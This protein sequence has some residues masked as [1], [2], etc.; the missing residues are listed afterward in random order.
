MVGGGAGAF[1]GDVHRL[2]AR[3][4]GA[5]QLVCG[6]FSR[7]PDNCKKTGASLGLDPSRCYSDY[8]EMMAKEAQLPEN[9]RMEFVSIVTPNHVHFPVAKAALE[10]GFHVLSDKPATLNLDEARALGDIVLKSG[11]AYGLTHTYLGYPLVSAARQ[12]IAEGGIG[13][14]RKIYAEYIQ[15]WL[16]KEV[17]NKQADWR[18][19]P[20]R[21]GISGCMGDIGTHA[22]NLV[23]YV[24]GQ[25]MSHVAADLSIFV[26]G[27]RLDD[28]GSALFRMDGGAKGTLSASQVCVGRENSLSIRVYGETG[29]LEWHQEEP[30]TLLRTYADRPMEVIR[31]AHGYLPESIQAQ[32]RTPPG[33]PEGYLE[34]FANIYLE[35]VEAVR[36]GGGVKAGM[37]PAIR[38][39]AF[40]EALVKSSGNNAAWTE[41][42]A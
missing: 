40:V 26:D 41:I 33:H 5:V 24:T 12:I 28:D 6:A 11:K 7:D 29:G 10:A 22:H 38:G 19:D 17:D 25:R 39:M 1:I 31:S 8:E 3:L 30:N 23:E 27:R 32:Y 16:A 34:A 36:S 35:F 42:E 14:V 9:E 37:E 18:T 2:A 4:D 20:S 13:K 21:S 15:G